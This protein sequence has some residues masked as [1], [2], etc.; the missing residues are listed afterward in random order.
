M[1]EDA[2]G[3]GGDRLAELAAWLIDRVL[4]AVEKTPPAGVSAADVRSFRRRRAAGLT[5]ELELNLVPFRSQIEQRLARSSG[6]PGATELEPELW[7]K[8]KRTAANL[9]AMGLAASKPPSAMTRADLGVLGRYSGWG[10][11]SIERIRNQVPAGFPVPEA[12]GLIH[13]YYTPTAV[14]REIARVLQPHVAALPRPDGALQVLEPSAGIGRFVQAATPVLP[15]KTRWHT[16]EYSELSARMLGA[17]RP[18]IDVYKGPFERWVRESG[19]TV[20]GKLGLVLSNPPYGARGAALSEDPDRSYR[21]RRAYAY[22]LRR[23]LDL[24]AP[25]GVGVFLVPG[26]FLTG[27]SA[28]ASALRSRVLTRHH[29]MS[30]YRLPSKLFP[31]ANLVVD[32]LFFRARGGALPEVDDADR[33]IE[34]GRYFERYPGHIL[35]TESGRDGGADDQTK[36]PRWGY[37]VVGTFSKLP[38]LVERPICGACTLTDVVVFPGAAGRKRAER[39]GV[40][41]ALGAATDGLSGPVATAAR[42]G[43]RVDA[44]LKLVAAGSDAALPR[45]AELTADLTDWKL[46][47]GNP[48][49]HAGLRKAAHNDRNVAAERFLNAW[50]ESGKLIGGLLTAPDVASRYTGR[51]GDVVEL[52]EW[53]HRQH[54]ALTVDAL[55][56]AYERTTNTRGGQAVQAVARSLESLL[57]AGWCLDGPHF[58]SLVPRA[59][60]LSGHLWPKVERCRVL[61][62]GETSA[63]TAT[64]LIRNGKLFGRVPLHR[65]E[66]QQRALLE[67]IAPV[68]LDDIDGLAPN[69]GWIPLDVLGEFL[70]QG[71]NRHHGDGAPVALQRKDGLLL[72]ASTDVVD[73][74]GDARGIGSETTWLLGWVNH[75]RTTFRPRKRSREDNIDDVRLVW[76]KKWTQDFQAWVRAN[77]GIRDRLERLYNE[78]FRG[79]VAPS[80]S[81]AP[82][83]LARW[84]PDGI[85]LHP[86]QAGGARRLIDNR[87]GLLA[88][89][90]GVGK[91]YTG[92]AAMAK[93][94]ELGW[95]RRPV[96]LVPNSLVWKWQADVQ[97]VLP[98]Y[99]VVVIG[100][101]MKTV[102]RGKR[103]GEL[104]SETD[105]PAD[106]GR[107][108]SQFQAGEFDVAIVSYS[109][110]PRTRMNEDMLR[111]YAERTAAI[112]REIALRKRNAAKRGKPSERDLAIAE[113]GVAAWLA[114]QLEL[115]RGWD[116]DPGVA[117]DDIGVDLLIVDEAQNFKNLY[118]PEARE[119]GVPRFMGNA[120]KG[121]KRAWHLDFRCESVRQ[122]TGGGVILL[123]ATPAKNS[124]LEFYNLL[125]Y[126]DHDV[127]AGVG[128][129]DPEQ[130]I[131]RYCRLETKLVVT[132]SMGVE[133][134]SACVGF[135]NLHELRDVVFRLGEFKTAQDVGLKLPDPTVHLVQVDMDASQ[136]AK[137]E[138]Y[139]A[140]IENAMKDKDKRSQILGLLARMA[141]V[142]V[143]ADLDQ[144]YDWKTSKLAVDEGKVKP[145]SPK[146]LALAERVMANR[147][148]GHIVFVDNVAAHRWV[149]ETLVNAGVPRARI[150]VLNAKVAGPT[151]KRQQIA[152]DFNGELG[153]PAKYDVVIA[154]AI[155]YEGVD[156]Q[157]RTCAVHHLDLPWE[158]ATL[159]QRN[160]RGVRQGNTLA[161]IEINY[162]FSKA[163]Q[164]GMRFNLIQG[165][166]GWMTALL[167]GQDRDTNNPAA[168]MDMG[169]EEVLL[170]ISRNPEQTALRLAELRSK[171]EE[172]ARTRMREAATK[173]LRGAA[174]RFARARG[175][176]DPVAAARLREEGEVRLRDLQKLDVETWPWG[177]F[178]E[179]ARHHDLVVLPGGV[180]VWSGL[181][182]RVPTEG[183]DDVRFY[184]LGDVS[185]GYAWMREPGEVRWGRHDYRQLMKLRLRPEH[186][187]PADW[188]G[189]ADA[190]SQ[191]A[192]LQESLRWHWRDQNGLDRLGWHHA[193]DAWLTVAWSRFGAQIV[194]KLSGTPQWNRGNQRVPFVAN[195]RLQQGAGP[196]LAAG[197]AVVLPPTAAG[198]ATFLELAPAAGLKWTVL[199]VLARGWWGRSI[200]RGL[201]AKPGAA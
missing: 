51:A 192:A 127:W 13:E 167:A 133:Q 12:R 89:D 45:W 104:T 140:E 1:I 187:E 81:T 142:A 21:D 184:E 122:R 112:K 19:P 177:R 130:F 82:L 55:I 38:D 172:E 84:A 152:R 80:F 20:A 150:A 63:V 76:A 156:L 100:S 46:A 169:P 185:G 48:W 107:K 106:R 134:R 141:L 25:G 159:Q 110:F 94:R 174:S 197:G 36:K 121:S 178:I 198:F 114:E 24:L 164:D 40:G 111:A 71:P 29:L 191:A 166:R 193:D 37:E 132:S 154:N 86:H 65:I 126:V 4:Q 47:N 186:F 143:H 200:P 7:S 199:N 42:I 158:P 179:R 117:W 151:A 73:D 138:H 14:V 188:P 87:G 155:A 26:G 149:V 108:W 168:Q 93:A 173:Q 16:V 139:V 62:S 153:R 31:G 92:I 9:A 75:D 64:P 129:T 118:L 97:R 124:P 157:T 2:P 119:H 175:H 35:G 162:Y 125:Q 113:E 120:G 183:G 61:L 98:D 23:A 182:L 57:D 68:T 67:A 135:V 17:L 49:A 56:Q 190:E 6:K 144:G 33:F 163:S 160:G 50:S 58:Q 146:F 109:S 99:R 102:S 105:S 196:E 60:Y 41:R 181:R 44:Y 83:Q 11:L 161:A 171:R 195:G 54:G 53:Q 59:A 18:D 79:F 5:A 32:L 194:G 52:A 28:R 78:T 201:L 85:Q 131:D 147:T 145:E 96:I 189:P 165:K 74:L 101:N 180:P 176:R 39:G 128:I 15:K 116:Y 70:G 170:L 34:D 88:F 123:S 90:V 77:L 136:D 95:A 10:G 27:R 103:K 8:A 43:L 115:P 137:Y 22:F 66:A 148:C 91:T 72:P 3:P 30:A 69:Q